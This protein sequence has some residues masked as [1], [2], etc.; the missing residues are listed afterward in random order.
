MKSPDQELLERVRR[1]ETRLT[2][3][4]VALGVATPA[5]KPRFDP[6]LGVIQLPSPHTSLKECLNCLPADW[7]GKVKLF[8]DDDYLGSF[9]RGN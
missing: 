8:I 5:Q 7:T 1:I 3:A 9:E 2:S 4:L 6:T